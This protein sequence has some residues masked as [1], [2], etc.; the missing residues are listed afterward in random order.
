[1]MIFYQTRKN[2]PESHHKITT[3]S[4]NE[5]VQLLHFTNVYIPIFNTNTLKET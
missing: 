5:I 4:N 3:K 1:M 2:S